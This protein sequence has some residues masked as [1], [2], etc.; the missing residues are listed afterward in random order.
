M[1]S[2]RI[3]LLTPGGE[4]GCGGGKKKRT[5]QYLLLIPDYQ[6]HFI[7]GNISRVLLKGR[8]EKL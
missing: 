7:D 6:Q 2:A 4:D 5:L 1:E 8:K 3:R